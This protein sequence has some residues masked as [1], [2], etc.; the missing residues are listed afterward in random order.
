MSCARVLVS[1]EEK[2][3]AALATGASGVDMESAAVAAVGCR[4]GVPVLVLRSVS[5]GAGRA[6]PRAALASAR[7]DGRV[8]FTGVL[9]VLA[10]RPWELPALLRVARD[11]N[12]ADQNLETALMQVLPLLVGM[13]PVAGPAGSS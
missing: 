9:G 6:L 2:R 5:D 13:P 4:S 11:V 3:A 12:A 1:V 10:R 8:S 7:D